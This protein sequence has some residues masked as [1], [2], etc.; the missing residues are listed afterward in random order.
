MATGFSEQPTAFN[1][2]NFTSPQVAVQ[3]ALARP[4]LKPKGLQALNPK[5]VA[6]LQKLNLQQK[7]RFD[8]LLFRTPLSEST[9]SSSASLLANSALDIAGLGLD[10]VVAKVFVQ[11]ITVPTM[12]FQYERINGETYTKDLEYPEL[13]QITFIDDERGLVM[14]YLQDWFNDVAVPASNFSTK[15]GYIFRDN[16]E[17]ARRTG[18]L[19]L[20]NTR[21][22]LPPTYPRIT[23]YGLVPKDIGDITIGQDEK[24]HLTYEVNFSVREVRI[25]RFV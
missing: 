19:M 21:G 14:R 20:Q 3:N 1:P 24:D 18:I 8:F 11:K 10:L 25:S 2:N 5:I 17:K 16:Q 15:K 13:V 23:Y 9:N 6:Q 22:K 7:S 4:D 12:K